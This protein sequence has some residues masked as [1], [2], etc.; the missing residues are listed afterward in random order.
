[1]RLMCNIIRDGN[2]SLEELLEELKRLPL[3]EVLD[4]ASFSDDARIKRMIDKSFQ[5]L[6]DQEKRAFVSLAA[7]PGCFGITDAT[8]VL[9]LK[10]DR[11][12]KKIIRS[13]ERKSLI[14]SHV[15]D[16]E[17]TFRVHPLLRSFVDEKKRTDKGIGAIFLSAKFRLYY[18]RFAKAFKRFISD[19]FCGAFSNYWKGSLSSLVN[20]KLFR[21]VVEVLSKAERFLHAVW[22]GKE[23][24]LENRHETAGK[25][26]KKRQN[27]AAK[28]KS[29]DTEETR[30]QVKKF[31]HSRSIPLNKKVKTLH[32]F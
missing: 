31:R 15:E 18:L 23:S 32:S 2:T 5:R 27:T 14:E 10:T 22:R 20:D 29:S 9:Y 26:A 1:M 12:T 16:T 7:F 21:R 28:R 8:T 3:V 19:R 11:P 17:T 30:A 13:L 24:L 4:N 25:E 6:T